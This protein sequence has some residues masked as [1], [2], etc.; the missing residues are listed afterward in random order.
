MADEVKA[1]SAVAAQDGPAATVPPPHERQQPDP[2]LQLS[3]GRVGAGGIALVALVAAIILGV[4]L[5]GLNSR[6]PNAQDVG[7]PASAAAT[8]QGAGSGAGTRNPQP[9]NNANHNGKG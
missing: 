2:A 7:A 8:P 5:W 3:A 4:V 9:S 1:P 6:A